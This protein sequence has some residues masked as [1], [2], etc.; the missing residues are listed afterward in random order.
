MS[1]PSRVIVLAEDRRHQNFALGVLKEAGYDSHDIYRCP[2]PAGR[3]AGEQYVREQLPA[4]VLAFRQR[5]ARAATALVVLVDADV[6]STREIRRRLADALRARQMEPLDAT[7]RAAV[8]VPRRNIETW[9][10][11]LDGGMADETTDYRGQVNDRELQPAGKKFVSCLKA[12]PS[13]PL[14]WLPSMTESAAE[15]KRVLPD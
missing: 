14:D 5:A 8:L 2:L 10:V 3:G 7:E 15:V 1:K 6:N 13:S 11:V 4:Q 12:A 9:V